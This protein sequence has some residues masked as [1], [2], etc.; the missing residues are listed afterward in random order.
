MVWFI[1]YIYIFD[2]QKKKERKAVTVKFYFFLTCC[3]VLLLKSASRNLLSFLPKKKKKKGQ[4]CQHKRGTRCKKGFVKTM[5]A[6]LCKVFEIF[7][8]FGNF[9]V[10]KKRTTT[11]RLVSFLFPVV[12]VVVFFFLGSSGRG[13]TKI[14]SGITQKSKTEEEQKQTK[15]TKSCKTFLKDYF[16]HI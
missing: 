7:F 10:R 9:G 1:I 3:R 2:F 8:S 16:Y 11:R 13:T 6:L 15:R 12:F 14:M 5:F 4:S